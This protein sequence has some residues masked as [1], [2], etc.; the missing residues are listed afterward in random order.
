MS[1]AKVGICKVTLK[2]PQELAS[3][4]YHDGQIHKLKSGMSV[5]DFAIGQRWLSDTETELGLGV[6]VA[7]DERAV[8]ILF[9]DSE[10]NRVY[11]KRGAP[12]SR[13]V[14]KPGDTL[15]DAEGTEHVV[16]SLT[17]SGGVLCYR[18]VGLDKPIM[19]TRLAANIQLARPL[20][21]LLASQV[22]NLEWYRLR[23]KA[24]ELENALKQSTL[25]GVI[26]PRV[27][28][29]DHQLFIASEVG[30]RP[31]PRVLL[32]DEV[33]LGKTIEA[34]LVIHKQLAAGLSERVLVVVPDSLQFQWLIEL[35]RK[36]HLN[37]SL[38]DLV[39]T[40]AIKEHDPDANPF[41][42]EQLVLCSIDLLLDHADLAEAAYQA[43]FDLIC[44]DEAHHLHWTPEAGGNAAYDLIS[45]F[46]EATPSVLLLT[47][48]PEQMGVSSHF[49]RLRLLDP[50]RFDDLDHFIDE[51]ENFTAV[52]RL[53]EKLLPGGELDAASVDE[54]EQLTGIRAEDEGTSTEALGRL[55]DRHGTGRVLFRNTRESVQ[56]FAGRTPHAY[57]LPVP[58]AYADQFALGAKLRT[59]LWP[60]AA[61]GLSSEDPRVQW[62]IDL[63]TGPLK[64]EKVLLIARSGDVGNDLDNFLRLSASIKTA[65]F[66]EDM[67]LLERDQAA[68]YFAQEAGAQILLAS[69]VGSEGRNFQFVQHLVLFDL[70]PNPDVLEQR[71]GRLDR[72]GQ[73]GQ[74]HLHAPYFEGTAHER[75]Y[76]WFNEALGVLS[77]ISPTAQTIQESLMLELKPALES[78]Q[79]G[80]DDLLSL[81]LRLRQEQEALLQQGRDRLLELS[82]NRPGASNAIKRQISALDAD[83]FLGD[84]LA[85]FL[86]ATNVHVIEQPDNTWVIQPADDI[87]V[88]GLEL[89]EDGMTI[90]FDRDESLVRDHLDFMTL[91]HPLTKSVFE[92]MHREGFGNTSV[93]L[94]KSAAAPEGSLLVEAWF[95]VEV[96]APKSLALDE[97][98]SQLSVRVLIGENGRDV[99]TKVTPNLLEPLVHRL[100]KTQARQ[101]I[102][103]RR[104]LIVDLYEKAA[105]IAKERM[106]EITEKSL[107]VYEPKVTRE[108][109]RLEA[110]AQVNP[111]VRKDE[112]E[113]IKATRELGLERLSQLSLVPDAI[114]VLVC[115]RPGSQA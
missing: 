90:S 94:L 62:L 15:M 69:E 36:F 48:T 20:E 9:P 96:V 30:T 38:F 6:I 91:E 41:G 95:R 79:G 88:E 113:A 85:D 109:E 37:F 87:L 110:L 80:F 68:A 2:T 29:I 73:K 100:G 3:N 54:I 18:C 107:K 83:P 82:S 99:S 56:G 67:S 10:E 52:A 93:A 59:Q 7:V 108:I 40:A 105:A 34:G 103:A 71:I 21:R 14:F 16:E 86:A 53:A 35:K 28:L 47:A 4:C 84:F 114:R 111:S 19:E 92:L 57:P 42:T 39:R 65:L 27:G 51:S 70:P 44:V 8:S 24:R 66:N 33:G 23:S 1:G 63:L 104:D 11:A 61:E 112:V 77:G 43:G 31:N 32:A 22:E 101:V 74:I 45:L 5:H 13:V 58:A 75:L 78:D 46:A 64:H 106:P 26:G 17:E 60:E 50:D 115:V 98:I 76:R 12:L 55:I 49:A 89:P 102:K 25:K 97:S 81:A 72:I